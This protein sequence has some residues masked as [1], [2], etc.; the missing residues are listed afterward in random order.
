MNH[1]KERLIKVCENCKREFS[2]LPSREKNNKVRFCSRNCQHE[3]FVGE[4]SP[5]W[6]GG[7]VEG[8]CAECGKST[9]AKPS[10]LK[11]GEGKYCSK[12]CRYVGVGK[13]NSI[14]SLSKRAKKNCS[15]C[16]MEIYIKPSHVTIEGT[17]CSRRCMKIGYSTKLAGANNPNY[18]HGA[19]NTPSYFHQ[20][21]K[22]WRLNN[23][24]K[25]AHN[26]RLTRAIRKNVKGGYSEEDVR[27]LWERQNGSCILCG[28]C[29]SRNKAHLDHI[30]PV[31]KGGT[32]YIGNVQYLC[33]QCNL[34]K[35]SLLPIEA[36]RKYGNLLGTML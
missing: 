26:N 27:K 31:S 8:K 29:L 18:R 1:R 35:G 12:N 36:K 10:H 3:Y 19:S 17:Y 22:K 32:N 23:K 21:A 20:A 30:I 14:A 7:L 16:D 24:D 28:V 33:A 6:R 5:T 15:V 13:K 4:R 25:V 2:I 34:R 9:F 11:N